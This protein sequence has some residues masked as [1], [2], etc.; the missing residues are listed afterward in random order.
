MIL[1]EGKSVLNGE[2]IVAIVTAGSSNRKTGNMLQV[3]ILSQTMD[4][5]SANRTGADYGICGSCPL[6]GKA[7]NNISG[8]ASERAC[9]VLLQNAPL[10]VWK[11]YKRGGYGK[12]KNLS[13]YGAGQ[14]IRLGAYGDPAAIPKRVINELLS[15][16]QGWTGYTHQLDIVSRT[17][18]EH[19]LDTVMISCETLKQAK[20]VWRRKGRTFRVVSDISELDKNEIFCPATPEGGSKTNCRFCGL[21][22]GRALGGKSIAVLAHGAGKKH[23]SSLNVIN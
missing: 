12:V 21:C 19:L 13:K 8:T 14:F 3:W 11:K 2:P 10:A 5:I 1:Y 17:M 9:Y 20:K 22:K 6:K 16:A 23:V 15:N 7:N 18:Q 4:P